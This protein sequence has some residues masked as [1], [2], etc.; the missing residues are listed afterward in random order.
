MAQNS[1][2]PWL[3]IGAALGGLL[4]WD[5]LFGKDL[6]GGYV[7][8][9][10]GSSA[11]ATL[12]I[13]QANAIADAIEQAVWGGGVVA[14]PWENDALFAEQLMRAQNDADVGL[15]MNTY[16]ER[17][18]ILAPLTLAETVASYLDPDYR[19]AVNLDYEQKGINLQW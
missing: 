7:P 13:A 8:P 10:P 19:A 17:G 3:P 14:S 5:K 2:I 16:G 18:T 9:N 1:R 12:T 4:L 15:I 11:P 6:P